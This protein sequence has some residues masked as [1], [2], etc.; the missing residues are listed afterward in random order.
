MND[1]G[2]MLSIDG[3]VRVCTE[4]VASYELY[5]LTQLPWPEG[6]AEADSEPDEAVPVAMPDAPVRRPDLN[7]IRLVGIS[8]DTL[9][10]DVDGEVVKTW[11]VSTDD[12]E[13]V[14]RSLP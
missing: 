7:N 1:F 4:R 3:R 8:D 13:L 12:L 5:A 6:M 14:R 10:L 11:P 2:L 9:L